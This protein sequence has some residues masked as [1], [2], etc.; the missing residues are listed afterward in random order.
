MKHEHKPLTENSL[1]TVCRTLKIEQFILEVHVDM[2][3]VAK[4]LQDI[5]EEDYLTRRI[6]YNIN[7][8]L[9]LSEWRVRNLEGHIVFHSRGDGSFD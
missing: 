8:K 1:N 5:Y 4:E 2:E 6:L 3:G 9:S 7:N